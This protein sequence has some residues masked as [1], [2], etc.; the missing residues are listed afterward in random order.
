[1]E[2]IKEKLFDSE[3]DL[4]DS[5]V[6]CYL[7]GQ[8]K[9][10][11]APV[12]Y[13]AVILCPGGGY[14]QLSDRESEIIALNFL[15]Q[16]YH[17]FVLNYSLL[18]SSKLYP[19]PLIEA[20]KT[21]NII[22]KYAKDYLIDTSRIVM[23]GFSA[24]GHVATLYSGMTDEWIRHYSSAKIIRPYR[25]LLG[26]PLIDYQLT[27]DFTA[28]EITQ[29]LGD[30]TDGAAQKLVTSSTPPTFIWA[31]KTDELVPIQNT[32]SYVAALAENDVDFEEHIFGWGPHGLSLANEQTD[33]LPTDKKHADRE[34]LNQHV[35]KWFDLAIEWLKQ[36]KFDIN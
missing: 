4:S 16:D 2:I 18:P 33:Y 36:T 23:A 14:T 15:A 6:T 29:V 20:A 34:F 9:N 17:V 22:E 26:Y 30:F 10:L 12:N 24:G 27:H 28:K 3:Y 7:K 11:R 31:T 5:Y 25:Q 35:A 32:L 13:P 1:M 21:F 19:K 8:D